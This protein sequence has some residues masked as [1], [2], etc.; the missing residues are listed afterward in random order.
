M[1]DV[2]DQIERARAAMARISEGYHDAPARARATAEIGQRLTRI[3]VADVAILVAAILFGSLVMPLG[4]MGALLVMALLVAATLMLALAPSERRAPP[5]DR[6]RR[7]DLKVLPAQ[8]GRW[9]Q[10]Q[11]A[12][13][14]APARTVADRI[15]TRLDALSP[16]LGSIDGD[17]APALEIRRLVGE[18]LPAFVGDYTRVPDALRQT[19]RNGR[20]P[21]AE[22]TDGLS[23][24][25]RQIADMTE[26][27]AQDDL[28]S[29][30]T[31]RR[32]LETKYSAPEDSRS[33]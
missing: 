10:S 5:P 30:A 33:S 20:T 14:P 19:P 31:R 1:S 11:R 7:A 16:Q 13:L 22:L 2:D 17:S 23:L 3:A 26:R 18:Q 27:L 8:T 25:E 29:L 15:R 9:L 32:Y 6:L 12:S 4:I 28:D 21:D 24:I